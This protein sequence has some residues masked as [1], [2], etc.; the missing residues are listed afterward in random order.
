MTINIEAR[1]L[2]GTLSF[3]APKKETY[4]PRYNGNPRRRLEVAT[5]PLTYTPSEFE[6][7]DTST[8]CSF[9]DRDWSSLGNGWERFD[10]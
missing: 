5:T 10:E 6:F 9:R 1:E 2:D 7:W 3:P 8:D 4:S